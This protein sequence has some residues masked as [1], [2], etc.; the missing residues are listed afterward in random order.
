MPHRICAFTEAVLAVISTVIVLASKL[1][2]TAR[3]AVS[4][5]DDGD[6]PAR[7]DAL[8]WSLLPLIGGL[9][10]SGGA[11]LL[12]SEPERRKVVAGRAIFGCVASVAVPKLLSKVHPTVET[13]TVDPILVL[14]FGFVCGILGYVF[15]RAAVS[16]LFERAPKIAEE[17]VDAALDRLHGGDRGDDGQ[18]PP[19]DQEARSSRRLPRPPRPPRP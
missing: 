4:V 6:G 19:P 17:Q 10:A 3:E 16:R 14:F 7:M 15:S 2:L 11:F 9:L 8:Q 12:N 1:L 5:A 13:M 18:D